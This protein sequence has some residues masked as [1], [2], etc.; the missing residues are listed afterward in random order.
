MKTAAYILIFLLLGCRSYSQTIINAERLGGGADSTIY[1][2]SFLYNGTKGNSNT[3]QLD[4]SPAIILL[5]N[6]NEYKLFGDYSLLSSSGKGLL[7]SGFVHLRHNFKLNE[8]IKTFEF[9]QIQF[10]D[11]LLL[12]KREVF[13]AGLRFSML[14]HDSLK[15]DAGIGLMRELE[16]LNETTLLPDE[17]SVTKYYRATCVVSFKWVLSK[18]VTID[19]VI[20]YQPYL[21]DFADYRLLDDFSLG[22]SLTDHF[23]LLT[24]LTSRYDSKPP[25][26]LKKLDNVIR[27]GFN[28]K[29]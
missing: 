22:V 28:M 1:S 20:Y 9:Y 11:I 6:K 23:E 12:T 17:L 21:K 2:L 13:G 10:N 3:D 19:N 24:S 4:I 7:N 15:F 18:T 26:T 14:N 16:H 29:F 27:F 5:R 25:G 8:R